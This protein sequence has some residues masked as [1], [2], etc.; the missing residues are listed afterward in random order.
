MVIQDHHQW[1][2]FRSVVALSNRYTTAEQ[3]YE[4]VHDLRIQCIGD[5]IKVFKRVSVSGDW[6]TQTGTALLERMEVLPRYR[7]WAEHARA[8][9]G[10]LDICTVDVIVLADGTEYILEVN[11]TSSGLAPGFEDEDEDHIVQLAIDRIR[12]LGSASR[13]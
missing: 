1:A 10:G 4:G 13:A 3:F 8:L 9:F 12:E 5:D 6:K 2:D 7:L 11:G